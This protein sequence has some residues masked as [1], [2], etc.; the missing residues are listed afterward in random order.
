MSG[1]ILELVRHDDLIVTSDISAGPPT[2]GSQLCNDAAPSEHPR[3]RSAVS[4][5]AAWC[6]HPTDQ[7]QQAVV[8]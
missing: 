2:A 1:L 8:G 3:E 5:C 4:Q 7:P 6:W